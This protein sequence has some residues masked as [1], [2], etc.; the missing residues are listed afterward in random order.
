MTMLSFYIDPKVVRVNS[1]D[2]TVNYTDSS[3]HLPD[4]SRSW[5]IVSLYVT[6]KFVQ[7]MTG[8]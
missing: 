2:L 3:N 8:M 7:K 1:S 6:V 4:D 5:N